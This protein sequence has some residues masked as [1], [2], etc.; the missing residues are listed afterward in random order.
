MT[1]EAE[2][3]H[4]LDRIWEKG[5]ERN[6]ILGRLGTE[7]GSDAAI[8][9]EGR[10]GYVVVS[11]GAAGDQGVTIARDRV[12]AER[13]NF[14]LVR[15]RRELGELVIREAAA[16]AGGNGSGGGSDTLAGL[17]DVAI[18]SP[19]SGQSLVY[20]GSKWANV[21]GGSGMVAH[22]HE[23]SYHTG[24]LNWGTVN[25]TNSSIADLS[26]HAHSSLSGISPD[27]HHPHVHPL[28]GTDALGVTVHTATGLTPGYTLRAT[29]PTTF[30]WA[31]LQHDDLGGIGAD[32]HHKR[33]HGIVAGDDIGAV[34][35]IFGQ[36]WVV[37]GAVEDNVLGMMMPTHDAGLTE[38]LLKTNVN[39]SIQFGSTLLEVQT[40]YN[41]VTIDS[42]LFVADAASKQIGINRAVAVSPESAA[43][44]DVMIGTNLSSHTQRI[45]QKHLQTGR[46]WRIEDE[47]GSELIVLNAAGDLQ[48]GQP[49]FYS[50]LQGWQVAHTGD[51]EF[52]NIWARGELHATVFVKDEVHATG[53]TFMVA[54]A[55]KL[56]ADSIIDAGT[57]DSDTFEVDSNATAF[58]G[59]PALELTIESTK[60]GFGTTLTTQGIGN[61]IEIEDPPSGPALYF[62]PGEILR[63]KTE[64][65][66]KNNLSN[67]RMSDLW[68][69]VMSAT[70][71][72]GFGRYSVTKRSGTDSTI[73]AGSAIVSYGQRGDGRILM[74]SDLQY[75]PY[76][77]V[78]TTGDSPW[79]G[80]AGNIIPRMRMGQL[81]GVGV[82]EGVPQWGMIAGSDLTDANSGYLVASNLGIRLHKV[83]IRLN[84]GNA[85]TGLWTA[86]GD[87]SL[88]KDVSLAAQTGFHFDPATGDLT[89]GDSSPTSSNYMKWTQ[90]TGTLAVKG[91]LTI[92]GGGSGYVTTSEM[93]AADTAVQQT[94]DSQRIVKV[95]GSWWSDTYNIIK[96]GAT[97]GAPGATNITL[98]PAY[99]AARTVAAGQYTLTARTYFYVNLALA[100]TLSFIALAPT[101]TVPA[102]SYVLVAVVDPGPVGSMAS[103]NVV[104]GGTYISGG[105]IFTQ[106]ILA[107]NIATDAVIAR[108]I[109]GRD[110][111]GAKLALG[112]V[113]TPELADG[114]VTYVKAD[115]GLFVA[116][117]GNRSMGITGSFSSVSATVVSWTTLYLVKSDGT[118]VQI[119]AGTT[120]PAMT[121]RTFFYIPYGATGTVNLSRIGS[122]SLGTLAPNSFI[123]AVADLGPA[124]GKASITMVMGGTVI[125]GDSIATNSIIAGNIKAGEI[126]ADKL[127]VSDLNAINASSTT[128]NVTGALVIGS[129]ASPGRIMGGKT[130]Y[131][132]TGGNLAGFWIGY[133]P[134]TPVGYK[135]NIGNANSWLKWDGDEILIRTISPINIKASNPG[136]LFDFT[137]WG[138]AV[139][140]MT[141]T[142][143]GVL[144]TPSTFSPARI[145]TLGEVRT[146][147]VTLAR[148]SSGVFEAIAFEMT[149]SARRVINYDS[150]NGFIV[151]PADISSPSTIFGNTLILNTGSFIR[152]GVPSTPASGTAA[153]TTGDIR[154]DGQYI[155]VCTATNTWRKAQ[156][157]PV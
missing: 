148:T 41:T 28:V 20:N 76:I 116:M 104:A 127:D 134:N 108:T 19:T 106:S 100:G 65:D 52:N 131:G 114:A 139:S 36:K 21:T 101:A 1:H 10:P 152:I 122:G 70:Q 120:N 150:N 14:Q 121:E 140:S 34:H 9:V 109:K 125:S 145:A 156:L 157:V 26:D 7:T 30:A 17:S 58:P 71:S 107:T 90:A 18:T 29:S 69:E 93:Q 74:T 119:N 42:T 43:A 25:K 88:G 98:Y 91:A 144:G 39:G 92:A 79:L 80:T 44:L 68:L 3:A 135:F 86:E 49:G 47:F 5:N 132:G 2:L 112:A 83:P 78:F 8:D 96:W 77:D 123:V 46:L 37:V 151:F 142:D 60:A 124:S 113:D 40:A 53:G 72:D 32:Q 146:P 54:T 84:N 143:A 31:Q 147:V 62:S 111:T 126:T 15:M 137:S 103:V 35:T 24:Q 75:A 73:P 38:R 48:S 99:G 23:G 11:L 138:G 64:I 128:L 4:A 154:W 33:I 55:G 85:D 133:D 115:P 56:Y 45:K 67:L 136:V 63:V 95:A 117:G 82:L 87:L 81:Q 129:A 97:S 51:A 6:W 61:F 50:G 57:V 105:N 141:F 153:G 102:T 110:I 59:V 12:G 22:P 149:G 94:V 13:T 130:A 155:Y 66:Q 27:Q 16:V 118:V 89:I